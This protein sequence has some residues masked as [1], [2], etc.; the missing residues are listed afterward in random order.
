MRHAMMFVIVRV[1]MLLSV[2]W[3]PARVGLACVGLVRAS[4]CLG[5]VRLLARF[6]CRSVSVEPRCLYLVRCA[7]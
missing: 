6:L 4:M 7:L 3:R 2:G 1:C 5:Q